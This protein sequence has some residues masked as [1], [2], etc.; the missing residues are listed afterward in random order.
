M[1]LCC[2]CCLQQV[3]EF[4]CSEQAPEARSLQGIGILTVIPILASVQ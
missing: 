1:W 3:H 2:P 4:M